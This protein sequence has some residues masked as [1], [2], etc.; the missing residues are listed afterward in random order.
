MVLMFMLAVSCEEYVEDISPCTRY[1]FISGLH[2]LVHFCRILVI[3]SLSIVHKY[4]IDLEIL[5][6]ETNILLLQTNKTSCRDQQPP[7][8]TS[9]G[10]SRYQLINVHLSIR[11][12]SP[13]SEPTPCISQRQDSMPQ[14]LQSGGSRI[15]SRLEDPQVCR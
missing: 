10:I 12:T 1:S 5:A 11:S 7:R 6:S 8:W 9:F 14:R 13:H 15:R 3:E 2:P 4:F